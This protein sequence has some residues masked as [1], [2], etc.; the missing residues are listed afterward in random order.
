MEK[1]YDVFGSFLVL[2]SNI[3]IV[4]GLI[5]MSTQMTLSSEFVILCIVIG[6]FGVAMSNYD[7]S[8]MVS[9][10][11]RALDYDVAKSSTD[12]YEPVS[13]TFLV[14]KLYFFH[15]FL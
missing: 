8:H 9:P 10:K 11:N 13:V 6:F 14:Y 7:E 3:N 2:S 1:L 15:L 4:L 5:Q 12:A